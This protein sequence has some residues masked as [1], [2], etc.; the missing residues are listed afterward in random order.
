MDAP[1][2]LALRTK[3][4]CPQCY[5]PLPIKTLKYTHICGRTWDVVERA[6]EEERKAHALVSFA[7]VPKALHAPP[8]P[9]E[10]PPRGRYSN[11]L[12]QVN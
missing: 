10:I 2:R 8:S 5:R 3:T 4:A 1:C 12:A 6:H 11:L 7:H 9:R